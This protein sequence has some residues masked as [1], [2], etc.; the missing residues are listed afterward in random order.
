MSE[1]WQTIGPLKKISL[2]LEAGTGPDK[3]DLTAGPIPFEFIFGA[4]SRGLCP[5][6]FQLANRKE[7]DALSMRVRGEELA[8]LFQHLLIP[9]LAVLESVGALY[10]KVEIARVSEA[11][12]KE[13]IKAMAEAGSCGDH[14][15]GH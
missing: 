10:L 12:P 7:G 1:E 2:L 4:G 8:D 13:V 14:C 11:D 3:T 5:F 6:E 9:S 15:C